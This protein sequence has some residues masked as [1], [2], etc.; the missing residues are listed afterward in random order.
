MGFQDFFVQFYA[1]CWKNFILKCRHKTTLLIELALPALILLALGAMKSSLSPAS[2]PESIPG[3]SNQLVYGT[4]NFYNETRDRLICGKG[5]LRGPDFGLTS[6]LIWDCANSLQCV[7]GPNNLVDL[8]ASGCRRNYLAVAPRSADN[9]DA[10]AAADAFVRWAETSGGGGL[11]KANL[12]NATWL[13][14]KSEADIISHIMD[15]LYVIRDDGHLIYGAVVF[16]SG[17]PNWEYI[18]RFNRTS[19][20]STILP[21]IDIEVKTNQGK[22]S[23]RNPASYVKQYTFSGSF[24]VTNAV[25]SFIASMTC[26]SSGLCENNADNVTLLLD[27]VADFP[28]PAE[29]TSEFWTNFMGFFAILMIIVLLYPISNMIKALVTEKESK[30]REGMLMMAMRQDALWASWIFNFICLLLPLSILLMLIGKGGLFT[31]S[32]SG[33]LFL[34]FLSYLNYVLHYLY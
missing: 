9:L 28:N 4:G 8:E 12:R 32:S 11:F 34:Y 10:A 2:T 30:Q 27:M 3:N 33:L 14:F 21:D 20:P 7:Y 1:L 24:M 18:V 6:N 16:I 15:P 17:A 26:K 13:L 25:N 5:P 29:T 19:T 22:T 31:Y 23:G